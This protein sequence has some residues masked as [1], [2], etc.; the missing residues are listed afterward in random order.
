MRAPKSASLT[1][2]VAHCST[3]LSTL[4]EDAD[5]PTQPSSSPPPCTF[6]IYTGSQRELGC[7]RHTHP[8]TLRDSCFWRRRELS[9][10]DGRTSNQLQCPPAR[11]S[12]WQ[13]WAM[14]ALA[15]GARRRSRS[16]SRGR[17]PS[18]T[19]V[20][21]P[22][23]PW[24]LLPRRRRPRT[25]SPSACRRRRRGCTSPRARPSTAWRRRHCQCHSRWRTSTTRRRPRRS[26]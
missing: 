11:A 24:R 12:R 13:G 20:A 23:L 18:L 8:L 7:T 4:H 10:P 1:A 17:P 2:G 5:A 26:C 14:V 22:V 25:Q 6:L 16:D 19:V 15:G 3:S 21:L 9:D